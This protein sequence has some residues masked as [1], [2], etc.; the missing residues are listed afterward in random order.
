[1]AELPLIELPGLRHVGDCDRR[2]DRV[3]AQA[4]GCSFPDGPQPLVPVVVALA[5][6]SS[7]LLSRAGSRAGVCSRCDEVEDVAVGIGQGYPAAAVLV[8]AG[9]LPGAQG[10]GPVHLVI[11]GGD[12]QVEV[13]AVFGRV[14]FGDLAEGH[15]GCGAAAFERGE[16]L[17][18]TGAGRLAEHGGP[19]LGERGRVA[20]VEGD[21]GRSDVHR[22]LLAVV[23][24][25][26]QQTSAWC[27]ASAAVSYAATR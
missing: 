14:G 12:G 10:D 23:R 9:G 5:L 25:T 13:D 19:E 18:G 6:L 11:E 20:A 16:L 22:L 3:A 21:R 27:L 17:R 15:A 4:H 26:G 1:K 8:E 7:C 2:S 24:K